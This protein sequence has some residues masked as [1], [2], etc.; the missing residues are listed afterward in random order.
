MRIAALYC[1]IA[2]L[3]IAGCVGLPQY[4]HDSVT[5]AEVVRHVRCE[6]RNAVR[7]QGPDAW[8]AKWNAAFIFEFEVFQTAGADADTTFVFPL[9]QGATFPL[10]AAAGF[11]GNG[12]RTERIYYDEK[13]AAIKEFKKCSPEEG[14]RGTGLGGSLGIGDL[15]QRAERSLRQAELSDENLTQLDYNVNYVLKATGS[16]TPKFQLVPIGPERT[17]TGSLKLGGEYRDTQLLKITL[18]PPKKKE[19][20][21]YPTREGCATPVF[22]VGQ[23]AAKKAEEKKRGVELELKKAEEEKRSSD[24]RG[25]ASVTAKRRPAA[26]TLSAPPSNIVSPAD[27]ESL[28]RGLN[29]NGVLSI[30]GALR[31]EG[32]GN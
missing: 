5:T 20:C 32:I 26:R 9:N 3:S 27:R 31:R 13:L 6:M 15:F 4:F 7:A 14:V 25:S 19:K 21:E 23:L 10:A 18:K 17:F 8:I 1:G 16:V 29:T 2:S 24:T 22:V 30:D 12:T 11:T 28:Y